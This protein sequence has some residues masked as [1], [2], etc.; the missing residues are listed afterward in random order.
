MYG[1]ECPE[2][3]ATLDPGE[4]CDCIKRE[5]ACE[6]ATKQTSDAVNMQLNLHPNYTTLQGGVSSA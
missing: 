3:G 1:Y 5:E 6:A 2:C 4:K